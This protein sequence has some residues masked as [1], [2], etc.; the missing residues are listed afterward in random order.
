MPNIVRLLKCTERA[1]V[2]NAIL[3][4]GNVM[5]GSI[6]SRFDLDKSGAAH[7]F[8]HDFLKINLKTISETTQPPTPGA[9]PGPG[10][11]WGGRFTYCFEVYRKKM[12]NKMMRRTRFI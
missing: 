4:R 11:G 3:W 9:G 1:Y 7:H 10:P 6:L 2:L 12:V 8:M 5:R